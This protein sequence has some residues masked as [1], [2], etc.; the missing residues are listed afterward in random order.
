MIFLEPSFLISLFFQNKNHK[1]SKKIFKRIEDE[2]LV[3]SWMV[4]AEVLTVLRKLKQSDINVKHAYN[5]MINDFIIID[6][7]IY[8]EKTFIASLTNKV[9]F[10]DNLYYILMKDLEINEIVS[11]DPDFDIFEDIKRIH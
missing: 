7:T 6:D 11:F 5:S 10:F 3:I 2:K 4:I 9:G 1:K 8:Y